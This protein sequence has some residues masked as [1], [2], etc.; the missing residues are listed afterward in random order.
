[1]NEIENNLKETIFV[2]NTA[3]DVLN[4]STIIPSQDVSG[5]TG[6][7][8]VSQDVNDNKIYTEFRESKVYD[9][10]TIR[11]SFYFKGAK[12]V[13]GERY[14]HDKSGWK[15][16]LSFNICKPDDT[17]IARLSIDCNPYDDPQ[18]LMREKALEIYGP[19]VH[20]A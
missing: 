10:I 3:L 7:R 2:N 13:R 15:Q 4:N 11:K 8:C 18:A 16:T 5:L 9:C 20:I 14:Y 12:F 1:M 17:V 6:R 19:D